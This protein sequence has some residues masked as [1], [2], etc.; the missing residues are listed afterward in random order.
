MSFDFIDLIKDFFEVQFVG[1]TTL[2]ILIV[3]MVLVI[4]LML[5]NVSKEVIFLVPLPVF[6]SIGYMANVVWLSTIAY[7]LAGIYFAN[8]ILALFNRDKA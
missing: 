6:I 7:I 4:F 8:I 3:I 1:E 2:A 5:M